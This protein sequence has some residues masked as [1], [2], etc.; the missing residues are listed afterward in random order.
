MPVL[1][2]AATAPTKTA[3]A[4]VALPSSET[5]IV[6][7]GAPGRFLSLAGRLPSDTS[8]V[9]LT[10]RLAGT[11]PTKAVAAKVALPSSETGLA[12][13]GSPGFYLVWRGLL[14]VSTAAIL[15]SASDAAA[16][17][18]V[19]AATQSQGAA[20]IAQATSDTARLTLTE[21]AAKSARGKMAVA[22]TD[23]ARLT[24]GEAA[25]GGLFAPRAPSVIN[26]NDTTPAAPAGRQ[27]V[28]WQADQNNPRNVSAHIPQPFFTVTW[29]IGIGQPAAVGTAVTPLYVVP[30]AG[31]LV[32][33]SIIAKTAPVGSDLVVDLLDGALSLFGS[34]QL[35]LPAGSRQATATTFAASP[36]TIAP[37]DVLS[38]NVT[39]VG[40]TTPGQDVTIQLLVQ[41]N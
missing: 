28:K 38:L 41:L 17:H 24:L 11:A 30:A 40:S 4:K 3:A 13:S 22:A 29:G 31:T 7:A 14:P 5:G 37:G 1:F 27:N 18:L 34:A 26:L 15:H 12:P 16:L 32:S 6:P 39:Q 2:S 25:S 19:E 9:R 21:S 8:S 23:T 36:Q 20:P 35:H 10:L 33:V